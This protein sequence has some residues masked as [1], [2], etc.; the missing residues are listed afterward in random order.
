MFAAPPV[1]TPP[2]LLADGVKVLPAPAVV[3]GVVPLPAAVPLE[4]PV[5]TIGPPGAVDTATELTGAVPLPL[6]IGGSKL[7]VPVLIMTV[8]GVAIVVGC[9]TV[10]VVEGMVGV[11]LEGTEAELTGKGVLVTTRVVGA[12]GVV[13]LDG[14]VVVSGKVMGGSEL[15]VVVP[16]KSSTGPK[17]KP[18]ERRKGAMRSERMFAVV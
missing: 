1:L 14:G 17:A 2:V 10:T 12:A 3:E 5:G 13:G 16:P 6:G 9:A 15:P 11:R 7:A 18:R 4:M 8:V